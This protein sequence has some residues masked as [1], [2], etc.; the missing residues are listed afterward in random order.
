MK[1]EMALKRIK[2]LINGLCHSNLYLGFQCWS[3][4]GQGSFTILNEM[5]NHVF[6]V[7]NFYCAVYRLF[8]LQLIVSFRAWPDYFPSLCP[9]CLAHNVSLGQH[10]AQLNIVLWQKKKTYFFTLYLYISENQKR[11]MTRRKKGREKKR[12]LQ[13]I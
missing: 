2:V 12:C 11:N 3:L 4:F 8:L 9:I 7:T 6:C 13:N 10:V 5:G 1:G